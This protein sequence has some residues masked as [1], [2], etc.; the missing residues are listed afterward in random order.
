MSWLLFSRSYVLVVVQEVYVL[1]VVVQ[2]VQ[3]IRPVCCLV[4]Y[5]LVV[6]Q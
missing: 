2:K 1:V 4:I 3:C 5:V 6:V